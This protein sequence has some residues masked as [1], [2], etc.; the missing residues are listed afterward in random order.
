MPV[1]MITTLFLLAAMGQAVT[2]PPSACNIATCWDAGC[3]EGVVVPIP[4][5]SG[6]VPSVPMAATVEITAIGDLHCKDG[7]HIESD[8]VHGNYCVEDAP[9]KCGKYEHFVPAHTE[10]CSTNMLGCSR[11]V[12]AKCEP[13]IHWVTEKDWQ[14]ILE[15]LKKLEDPCKDLFNV[16]TQS[17]PLS[18]TGR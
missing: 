10:N 7:Q 8:S 13:D 11:H 6:G 16:K 1:T 2:G 17:C 4:C 14:D 5:T 9:K 18:G 12:D 15:R 3:H